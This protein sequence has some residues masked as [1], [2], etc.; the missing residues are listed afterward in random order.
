MKVIDFKVP[1][2]RSENCIVVN[3][4]DWVKADG[5]QLLTGDS[6]TNIQEVVGS[7]YTETFKDFTVKEGDKVVLTK[8]SA[9]IAYLRPYEI[10]DI[11]GKFANVHWMQVIGKF[12]DNVVDKEHLQLFYS[13]VMLHKLTDEEAVERFGRE[14]IHDDFCK[15]LY[16]VMKVGAH[17]FNDD[18]EPAI[19]CRPEEGMLVTVDD[20]TTTKICLNG[21]DLYF[22]D[23]EFIVDYFDDGWRA[24]EDKMVLVPYEDEK[25][26]S[27]LNSLVDLDYDDISE[28][29]NR[30]K[31]KVVRAGSKWV[32]KYPEDGNTIICVGRD[33]LTCLNVMGCELFY[34]RS[35]EY[36]KGLYKC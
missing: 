24:F 29:Y 18:W 9:N 11:E 4:R 10:P 25:S 32:E 36:F 27:L 15:G 33:Y 23:M 26:G 22:T 7:G 8:A 14:L 16:T 6:V 13:K 19:I 35:D 20:S 12:I 2:S 21:E 31:F 3:A 30:D 5:G 28:I 34:T 1:Y 17:S